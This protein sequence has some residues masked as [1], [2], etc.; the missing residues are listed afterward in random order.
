VPPRIIPRSLQPLLPLSAS[1]PLAALGGGGGPT[2]RS[3]ATYSIQHQCQTFWC[4]AAVTASVSDFYGP[5]GTWTQCKIAANQLSPLDCCG[6]DKTGP[7]NKTWNLDQPLQA[8]GHYNYRDDSTI[9]FT[10]VQTEIGG[11][12]PV[13]V[14]IVWASQSA[15]FVTII[16]WS[17]ASGSDWVDVGDPFY[18]FVQTPYSTL[19]SGYQ[20]NGTWTNTYI[21][22]PGAGAPAGGGAASAAAS[23]YP[24]AP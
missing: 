20:G 4:W 14:R 10:D 3:L 13:G 12:R 23:N 5:V 22:Q 8:V 15:H 21:T 1:P 9:L 18:G 24:V 7:C 2:S 16:G 6:V 11:P 19:V 17:T